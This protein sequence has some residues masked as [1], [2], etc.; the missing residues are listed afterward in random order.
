MG[1][2]SSGLRIKLVL[3]HGA[4]AE[5]SRPTNAAHMQAKA[6]HTARRSSS[7]AGG[8]AARP[9][10]AAAAAVQRAVPISRRAA[11]TIAA[12]AAGPGS[13]AQAAQQQQEEHHLHHSS[14]RQLLAA[15]AVLLGAAQP[16]PV[17][18]DTD[19]DDF[20]TTPSGLSYLD[21]RVGEGATPAPGDTIEIHWCVRDMA[22]VMHACLEPPAHIAQILPSPAGRATP[23]AT[24]VC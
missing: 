12:A 10:A 14:R 17:L 4:R 22:A 23:R 18:A 2:V 8:Q 15:G 20:V 13:D 6:S 11:G 24:K 5:P 1:V 9:A 16:R 3:W 19:T 7:S 21:I